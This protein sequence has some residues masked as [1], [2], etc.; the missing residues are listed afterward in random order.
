MS[1]RYGADWLERGRY[2]TSYR[3]THTHNGL[4]RI[5]YLRYRSH[6]P[7]EITLWVVGGR[8][9]TV[10]GEV[11]FKPEHTMTRLAHEALLVFYAPANADAVMRS[12]KWKIEPLPVPKEL[13]S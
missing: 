6:T 5:H 12:D 4:A 2:G 13:L 7:D 8:S 3:L 9:G 10:Y 11:F 1:F